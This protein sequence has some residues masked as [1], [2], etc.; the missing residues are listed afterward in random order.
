MEKELDEYCEKI[1]AVLWITEKPTRFNDLHNFITKEVKFK[2]S[3]PTL[4]ERLNHLKK[5]K[6]IL[7]KKKGKQNVTYE[8]NWKKLE[9]LQKAKQNYNTV[10]EQIVSNNKSL[11]LEQL[12][13]KITELGII[14]ELYYIK[15]RI[16]I[17]TEPENKFQHL[18]TYSLIRKL[19][20]IP[21]DDL[22]KMWTKSKED[23]QSVIKLLDEQIKTELQIILKP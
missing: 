22:V 4:I 17:L 14:A 9:Q 1:L 15:H 18:L 10:L 6:A 23:S 5:E 16:L 13:G 11:T 20:N 21:I 7:Q 8:L 3:R 12:I 2:M 19:Y